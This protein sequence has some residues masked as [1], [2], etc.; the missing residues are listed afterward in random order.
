MLKMNRKQIKHLNPKTAW[1][2][3]ALYGVEEFVSDFL[4]DTRY[5]IAKTDYKIMCQLYVKDFPWLFNQL[6][7]QEE[8]DHIAGLLEQY[9]KDYIEDIG[10]VE[11]LQLLTEEEMDELWE[12]DVAALFTRIGWYGKGKRT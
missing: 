2:Y 4:A 10:G 6:F 3:F 9:I 7:L 5:D 11:N 12:A 8:L 1:E